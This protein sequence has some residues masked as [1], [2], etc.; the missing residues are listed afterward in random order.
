MG[1]FGQS[2]KTANKERNKAIT[3]AN[4]AQAKVNASRQASDEVEKL[5]LDIAL[6][7]SRIKNV[8][9]DMNMFPNNKSIEIKLNGLKSILEQKEE[10]LDKLKEQEKINKENEKQ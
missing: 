9:V 2:K 3:K 5:V 7:K 1:T 8:T 10:E 6:T 4:I